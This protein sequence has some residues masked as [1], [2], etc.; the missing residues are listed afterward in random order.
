MTLWGRYLLIVNTEPGTRLLCLLCLSMEEAESGTGVR[1]SGPMFGQ[2][3]LNA[4]P[5]RNLHHCSM[6][7]K[8]SR[9]HRPAW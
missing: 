9:E 1:P 6:T 7:E 2:T 4:C 8:D 3:V 5:V